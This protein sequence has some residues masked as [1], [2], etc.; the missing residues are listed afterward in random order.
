MKKYLLAIILALLLIVITVLPVYAIANPD[1]TPSFNYYEIFY[2]VLETGDML[3]TAEGK[4]I[5][6]VEP[7]D[8]TPEEAFSFELLNVAGTATIVST[9]LQ[10]WGDRPIGIYLNATSV[11]T[12]GLV[13]GT[14][15]KMRIT[16]NPLIF[17]TQTGNTITQTLDASDY[18]NQA[19]GVDGGIPNDNELRNGMMTIAQHMEAYDSPASP[20]IAMVNGYRYLT[21]TGEALFSAGIQGITIMCPILFQ[22]GIAPIDGDPPEVTGTYASSLSAAQKWGST[23]ANGLTMFGTWLGINQALAGS[24]VMFAIVIAFGIYIYQKTE[25]GITVLLMVAATP[26]IGAYLGLMPMA[27]AFVL[28]IFIIVLLGYFFFS[29]GVL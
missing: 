25:S 1:S 13:V 4:V 2:N 19:L 15:Y 18:T 20:Y 3:I 29:R 7:T 9:P 8:Y 27:L 28:V 26:F 21:L 6:A 5:Y 17:A 10:A 16:G 11:T 23:A 14:A 22:S 24:V 12:K